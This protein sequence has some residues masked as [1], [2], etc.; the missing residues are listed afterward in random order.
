MTLAHTNAENKDIDISGNNTSS[1]YISYSTTITLPAGD[2]VNVMMARYCYFSPKITGSG[3]LNLFGGGERCYLGTEK[4][5][6][7]PVWSGF[8]GDVH[9]WPFTSNSPS[10]GSHGVLL[11]H[12]GKSSSPDNAKDDAKSGKVNTSMAN[13]RVTLHAG[14]TMTCEANTSGA[15]FR[16]GQLDTE[17]GSTLSGY[18]KKSRAVYYL[19]GGMNTNSTLAGTIKPTDN[20]NATLLSIVKEGTGTLTITGNNNYVSGG[21]RVL[22]GRVDIM[23]DRG[24]AESNAMRGA[25]GAKPDAKDA[26]AYVFG[27]GVLGG[28]GSI[29]GSVENYGT[30]EPGVGGTGQLTLCNYAENKNANL[31]LHP[32]SVLRFC[33]SS[34][35]NCNRLNI[36]GQV[37]YS[38]TTEDFMTSDKMPQIEMVVSDDDQLNVGDEITVLTARTKPED[39]WHFSVRANKYTW[40]IV[41]LETTGFPSATFFVA[42]VVSLNTSGNQDDPDNHNNQE[43]TMG[44]F[45]DDG[46]DCRPKHPAFL[47]RQESEEHRRGAGHIQ[48]TT[49]RPQ[50]RRQTV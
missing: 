10:A 49:E 26:I 46:I 38:N 15:G 18:Y 4:G 5:K 2:T 36:D 37:M 8:T 34:A 35:E 23:N 7:W 44:A 50:C 33:V 22:E 40:E 32:A 17:A 31:T 29:G 45:Y 14:A 12:G 27:N 39:D 25:L 21:L 42:R 6:A 41:E 16:I 28:T 19:L 13:N 11:A 1:S 24:E 43:S 47:C 20:D 9:V 48:G 3:T 30:I